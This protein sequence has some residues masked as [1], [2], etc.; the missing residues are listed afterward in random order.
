MASS[1]RAGAALEHRV[2]EY[3]AAALA[4]DR[5]VPRRTSGANDR[6]DISGVRAHGSRVV[7]ECKSPGP[8]RP[9]NLTEWYGEARR[10]AGNDDAAI[11]IIVH[12][13][14]GVGIDTTKKVGQQWVTMT[15]DDLV[16]LICGGV[17]PATD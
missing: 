15:L 13:R 2:A 14:H 4:D 3:L 12:K 8:G 11:G 7:V 1:K 9:V 17:L 16:W 5:I 10:E 6:G